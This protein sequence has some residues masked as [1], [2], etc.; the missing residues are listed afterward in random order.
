MQ[1]NSWVLGFPM[2][3]A[4]VQS[5]TLVSQKDRD[6]DILHAQLSDALNANAE[7]VQENNTLREKVANSAALQ[8]NLDKVLSAVARDLNVT[9]A[10]SDEALDANQALQE[11]VDELEHEN[12]MLR[13]QIEER[14]G[15]VEHKNK[16]IGELAARIVGAVPEAE[17]EKPEDVIKYGNPDGESVGVKIEGLMDLPA[18]QRKM[19]RDTVI[20]TLNRMGMTPD[21]VGSI[22]VGLLA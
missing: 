21:Q 3:G 15:L 7:L 22:R 19:A 14:D 10:K 5:A 18:D 20:E 16:V 6:L 1:H 11:Q 2:M 12:D 4:A 8:Q 9:Q 13:R 17:T